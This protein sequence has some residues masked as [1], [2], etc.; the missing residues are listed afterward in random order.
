MLYFKIKISIFPFIPSGAKDLIWE[1]FFES[2]NRGIDLITHFPWIDNKKNL[3]CIALSVENQKDIIAT[4]IVR[5]H[6]TLSGLRCAM[7]GMVCVKEAWRGLG[8]SAKL[9]SETIIFTEEQKID[10]LLLWTTQ[11]K[12]YSKHGF[13][14][15]TEN[16][17]TY[18]RVS[19]NSLSSRSEVKFRRGKSATSRGLPPFATKLMH[20]ENNV[21]ELTVLETA[22]GKALA[23]WNGSPSDVFDLAEVA[24]PLTW[25]LNGP[26]ASPIYEEMEKR[27]HFS[28]PL[29]CA[30]RMVLQLRLP[31][32]TP[33]ISVLDRI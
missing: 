31:S 12:I 4:L 33:Y 27:G 6:D 23:E 1:V 24:L 3:F 14:S 18:C 28:E 17:D 9:I 7:I 30:D 25:N 19:I 21:A 10:T 8:L 13:T 15:D 2:R 5:M 22:D 29:P 26:E 20:F 32:Y 11:P 16:R